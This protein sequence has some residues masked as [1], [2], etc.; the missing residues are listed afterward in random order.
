MSA[1]TVW[2]S[3]ATLVLLA[4]VAA[5]LILPVAH[6]W[7]DA[8]LGGPSPRA[9][10]QDAAGSP[11]PV[12]ARADGPE[13]V[14]Q[15]RAAERPDG[16]DVRA[17]RL[18]PVI[19]PEL[20]KRVSLRNPAPV[21]RA[22]GPFTT[23][24]EAEALAR[25]LG[26]PAT[27]FEVFESEVTAD[28]DYLVTV[29]APGSRDAAARVLEELSGRGVDSYLLERAGTTSVL[30]AGV[31]SAA[32]RADAQQSRLAGLG[33]EAA[34]EPLQRAHQVYHLLAR[35]PATAN[36]EVAPL[37]ACSDIAPLEQFL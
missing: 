36:P 26:L 25:R 17:P 1:N 16:G 30:A 27:D 33:Y 3:P 20:A 6:F 4:V 21:C 24:D 14:A 7:P 37:G 9:S 32:E 11:A 5:N 28:P 31:F 34:I 10:Q 12:A 19:T 13:A 35:L 29:R 8:G 2:D 18:A 22:W 15:S 23:L